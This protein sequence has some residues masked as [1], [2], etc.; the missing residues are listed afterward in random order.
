MAHL[1]YGSSAGLQLG[2]LG[3]GAHHP[4]SPQFTGRL[5]VCCWWWCSALEKMNGAALDLETVCPS[6]ICHGSLN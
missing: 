2:G 5:F 6:G 3:M 1:R 4:R